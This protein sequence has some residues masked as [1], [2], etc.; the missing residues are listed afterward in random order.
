MLQQLVYCS[1]EHFSACLLLLNKIN[2]MMENLPFIYLV[3]NNKIMIRNI[4]F[5]V[6]L[7]SSEAQLGGGRPPIIYLIGGGA[8]HIL[9]LG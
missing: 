4:V 6:L 1:S 3:K 8:T 2:I 7:P 5:F 9:H